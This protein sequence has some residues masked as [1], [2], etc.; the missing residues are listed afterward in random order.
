VNSGDRP[1]AVDDLADPALPE[2]D[3]GTDTGL[4]ETGV[5]AQEA[6]QRAHVAVA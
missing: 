2:A 6:E 3:R 4:A 1:V 5:L